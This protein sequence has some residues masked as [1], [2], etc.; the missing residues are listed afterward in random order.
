VPVGAAEAS[1]ASPAVA[2]EPPRPRRQP[3]VE[4]LVERLRK[5]LASVTDFHGEVA[6]EFML[7]VRAVVYFLAARLDAPKPY[8][9]EDGKGAAAVEGDL[10]EDLYDWLRSGALLQGTPI[11]EAQKLGGGRAD[12]TVV[13]TAHRVVNELKRETRDSSRESM[14][15]TYA[16]QGS[17]YDATD[18]PFGIVT[19]LDVSAEPPSTPRLDN[20]VW[21]HEHRDAGGTRWLVFVRVPGRLST[22]S[23]HTKRAASRQDTASS[24]G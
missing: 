17:S 8:E 4:V 15:A 23:A 24:A 21:L 18:Y 2:A 19:V 11:Y 14:E 7:V 16:E 3:F 12:I 6:D 13:F 10:Q 1:G 22:P 5:E 20:C 9:R